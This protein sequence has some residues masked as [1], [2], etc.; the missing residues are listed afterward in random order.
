MNDKEL[1]LVEKVLKSCSKS[2]FHFTSIDVI[3]KE[4]GISKATI[5][6]YFKSKEQLFARSLQ[7][8]RDEGVERLSTLYADKNLSLNE[9]IDTR[10]E[11]LKGK[12]DHSFNG[13]LFQLAYTEY[14]NQD[15]EISSVCHSYKITTQ[16]LLASLLR[17]NGIDN[18]QDKSIMAEL[19]YNGLLASLQINNC[20]NLI[21]KAKDLY[22][23]V[24]FDNNHIEP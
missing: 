3:A 1:I 10:F 12:V 21:D 13:C 18:Y 4:S 24:I 22:K 15:Q 6:K 8:Y 7:A 23:Q 16:E 17:D 9:K 14:C 5:Y 19:I 20:M 11:I 2:G